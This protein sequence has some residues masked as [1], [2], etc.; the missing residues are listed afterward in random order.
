[1]SESDQTDADRAPS[2]PALDR[3]LTVLECLA[4]SRKGFSVSELSRRLT[5]PKSSVHLIV[6]TFERRG[7]LLKAPSGGRYRFGL[8]LMSL[9]HLALDGLRIA[10]DVPNGQGFLGRWVCT[11]KGATLAFWS[12]IVRERGEKA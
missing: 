11:R 1:M 4:Q 5:L 12:R 6:R 8:K 9:G 7:Y 3:A 2:V 10:Q